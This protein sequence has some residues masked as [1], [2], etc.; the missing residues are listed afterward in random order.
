LLN[1]QKKERW[2]NYTRPE[3]LTELSYWSSLFSLEKA[4]LRWSGGKGSR[5]GGDDGDGGG[6]LSSEDDLR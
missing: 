6:L 2:D 5:W 4:R 1:Q 3:K